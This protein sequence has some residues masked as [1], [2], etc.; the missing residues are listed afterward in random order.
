MQR[1]GQ[2]RRRTKN[3]QILM[4]ENKR[5]GGLRKPSRRK[6]G[7][8]SGLGRTEK[9]ANRNGWTPNETTLSQI[10]TPLGLVGRDVRSDL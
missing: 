5:K 9:A 2:D 7:R 3:E 1:R 6:G 4:I 8:P 10:V